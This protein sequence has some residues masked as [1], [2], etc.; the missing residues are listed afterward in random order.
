[1]PVAIALGDTRNDNGGW[2][3]LLYAV[4]AAQKYVSL[5]LTDCTL[6]SIFVNSLN[7]SGGSWSATGYYFCGSTF[8]VGKSYVVHI[9]FPRTTVGLV[10]DGITNPTYVHNGFT[11]LRSVAGGVTTTIAN[12][13]NGC[14]TLTEVSF[15]N[16]TQLEYNAFKGCTNLTEV[17]FPN[18]TSIRETAFQGCIKLTDVSFPKA[19]EIRS[20]AFQ[21]CIGLTEVSFPE[22]TT[23]GSNG[24]NNGSNNP[25]GAFDDCTNLV[26][27][28]FLKVTTFISTYNTS[29]HFNNCTKLAEVYFAKA[30]TI[31][32]STTTALSMFNDCTALATLYIP[33]VRDIGNN[34]LTSSNSLTKITIAR[35]CTV[36]ATGQSTRVTAFKTYYDGAA[37]GQPNKAAGTYNYVGSAWTGDF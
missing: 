23:I 31:P 22:A 18:V 11:N 34:A 5:D 16:A 21:G 3:D 4:A 35:N 8:T 1:V 37:A 29:G 32:A 20:G 6:S 27:A 26:K 9:T 19:T 10:G 30:T 17:S 36:S 33:L 13:F 14:T 7:G 28:Y 25:A 12:A 15:P 2:G 24:V